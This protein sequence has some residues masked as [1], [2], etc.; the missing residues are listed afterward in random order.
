MISIID[1]NTSEGSSNE[2]LV[3]GS[4]ILFRFNCVVE[5]LLQGQVYCDITRIVEKYDT[6][7]IKEHK[8]VFDL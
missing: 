3:I 1:E 8:I 7:M 5:I 6:Y 2:H 4:V